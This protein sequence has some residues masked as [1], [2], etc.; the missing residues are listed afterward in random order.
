MPT[1]EDAESVA[2]VSSDSA[3]IS[4]AVYFFILLSYLS[5]KIN[6]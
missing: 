3:N 5:V 2:D 4:I 6:T 1:E